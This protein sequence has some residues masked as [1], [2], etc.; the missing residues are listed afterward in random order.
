MSGCRL[1]RTA[2]V[3]VE[4]ARWRTSSR[5]WRATGG[6]IHASGNLPIRSRS[7]SSVAS[8]TSFLTRRYSNAF[9]PDGCA[10]CTLAPAPCNAS[11][12]RRKG[13]VNVDAHTPGGGSQAIGAKPRSTSTVVMRSLPSW[14]GWM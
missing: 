14:E 6:A 10:R 4:V 7:A 12:A 8:R 13:L 3:G 2:L 9:T 5:S 1:V 11:T